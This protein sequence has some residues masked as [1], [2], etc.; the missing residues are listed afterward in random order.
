MPNTAS[1]TPPPPPLQTP[2]PVHS[3]PP[4]RPLIAPFVP[5]VAVLLTRVILQCPC[6]SLHTLTD[7]RVDRLLCLSL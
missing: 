1:A 4:P 6:A 7:Q 2:A 5:P 3:S